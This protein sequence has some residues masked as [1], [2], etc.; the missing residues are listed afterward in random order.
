MVRKKYILLFVIPF[1]TGFNAEAAERINP[2]TPLF[3]NNSAQAEDIKRNKEDINSLLNYDI[4]QLRLAAILQ[5]ENKRF[6]LF[7]DNI[8]R[9]YIIVKGGRI[10]SELYSVIDILEDKVVI[11]NI[12]GVKRE[13]VLDKESDK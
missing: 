4:S 1:Y 7:E 8:G 3:K 9:G 6:A 13:I 10:G 5:N 11:K 2:F 12:F